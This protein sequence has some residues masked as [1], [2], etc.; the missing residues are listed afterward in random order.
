[1]REHGGGKVSAVVS[2][3]SGEG[4]HVVEG[5]VPDWSTVLEC[6][7]GVEVQR[8]RV[9]EGSLSGCVGGSGAAW[10]VLWIVRLE[11]TEAGNHTIL[12]VGD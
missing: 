1:M 12:D 4:V 3:S 5:I 8:G 9:P 6:R 7:A 2:R 11:K 10:V